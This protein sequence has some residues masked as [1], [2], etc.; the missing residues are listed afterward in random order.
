MSTRPWITPKT[1]SKRSIA[2]DFRD[3][4]PILLTPITNMATLLASLDLPFSVDPVNGVG[5]VFWQIL[6]DRLPFESPL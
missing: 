1:S 2:L 6:R 4:Y 5:D 3:C